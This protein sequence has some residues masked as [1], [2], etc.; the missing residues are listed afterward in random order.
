MA[1]S[2]NAFLFRLIAA[3][4]LF[5]KPQVARK[6]IHCECPLWLPVRARVANGAKSAQAR[7]RAGRRDWRTHGGTETR[8][9]R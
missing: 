5:A 3:R 2:V 6:A 1:E 9:V 4:R 7:P 8:D